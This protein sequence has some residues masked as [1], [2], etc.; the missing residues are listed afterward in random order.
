MIAG[1]NGNKVFLPVC[2]TMPR[3]LLARLDAAARAEDRTRSAMARVL[4]D[5][6]L[7]QRAPEN[8]AHEPEKDRKNAHG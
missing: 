4:L 7:A 1:M 6:G 8:F 3:P 5:A 2:V